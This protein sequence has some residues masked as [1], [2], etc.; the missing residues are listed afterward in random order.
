[1]EVKVVE[2]RSKSNFIKWE[3][4]ILFI[5]EFVEEFA[6]WIGQKFLPFKC[7]TN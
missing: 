4:L 6:V 2:V 3:M 7:K 5:R 1:M